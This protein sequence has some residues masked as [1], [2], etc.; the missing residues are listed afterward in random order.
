MRGDH[1]ATGEGIEALHDDVRL[2][3]RAQSVRTRGVTVQASFGGGPRSVM[4]ACRRSRGLRWRR[5]ARDHPHLMTEGGEPVR[6]FPHMGRA[7]VRSGNVNG[8]RAVENFHRRC[9]GRASRK[10]GPVRTW[11][12]K[13]TSII[14]AAV[15][16]RSVEADDAA[17]V[18][19]DRG[20]RR[21]IRML[22]PCQARIGP[23]RSACAMRREHPLH[24]R[25]AE[26]FDV[27]RETG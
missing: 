5:A 13:I 18:P 19:H 24:D 7:A 26:R 21:E 4:R 3:P 17:C 2:P 10:N 11:R 25:E 22:L 27:R 8:E 14:R 1:A 15:A 23:L 9:D 12:K 20:S 16:T 6:Y